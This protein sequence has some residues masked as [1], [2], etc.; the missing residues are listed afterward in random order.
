MALDE[1]LLL[2]NF[3]YFA[4]ILILLIVLSGITIIKGNDFYESLSISTQTSYIASQISG[5]DTQVKI[6]LNSDVGL[7]VEKNLIKT[8]VRKQKT[9][10]D[11]VYFGPEVKTSYQDKAIIL[12]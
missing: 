5:T 7:L 3:E 2:E 10:V 1:E 8:K 9:S 4:S 12:N 6:N 11:K